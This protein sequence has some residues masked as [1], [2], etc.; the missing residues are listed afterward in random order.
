MSRGSA[1]LPEAIGHHRMQCYKEDDVEARG[2]RGIEIMTLSGLHL[3][4]LYRF[5]S[6]L[7]R[8]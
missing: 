4:R 1:G 8:K 3:Y 2:L 6:K 7:V 5:E